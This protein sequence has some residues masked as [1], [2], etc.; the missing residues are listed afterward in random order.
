MVNF[1]FFFLK[2][3]PLI[4]TLSPNQIVIIKIM[5]YPE[6]DILRIFVIGRGCRQ[7]DPVCPYL[8]N[9]C[10]EIMGQMI[11]YK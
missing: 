7:G 4:K 9:P 5:R 1:L 3:N 2:M 10:V 6:W 11:K 8:F